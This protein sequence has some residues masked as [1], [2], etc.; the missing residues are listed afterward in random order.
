MR[1]HILLLLLGCMVLAIPPTAVAQPIVPLGS[2][3]EVNSYT[4]NF[5][6]T[7]S[8]A[9]APDG[10]FV[11][12]WESRDQDYSGYGLFSQRYAGGGTALGVEM[13]VNGQ[14]GGDQLAADVA[15]DA[16][17][18]FVVVWSSTQSQGSDT[19]NRSIQMRRFDALG[20]PAGGEQQVNTE[21][22]GVQQSPA[23]ALGDDGRF[24]VV[25]EGRDGDGDGVRGQLFLSDG[26]P[27]GGETAINSY[28]TDDQN[29]VAV[30]RLGEDFVVVWQGARSPDDGDGYGLRGRRVSSTGTL[31]GA[32][33]QI[34]ADPSG[35]QLAP[36]L[37]G[38]DDGFIVS[39][40]RFSGGGV[41]SEIFARRFD[42][43]ALPLAPELQVNSYTTGSQRG[44]D[45]Q[46]HRSGNFVVV[47]GSNGSSGS[48]D[49]GYSVQGRLLSPNGALLGDS[50]QVNTYTTSYQTSPRLGVDAA[51]RFVVAWSSFQNI[52]RRYGGP[53]PFG[54]AV[55]DRGVRG[56]RFDLRTLTVALPALSGSSQGETLTLDLTFDGGVYDVASLAFSIDYDESCLGFDPTDADMDGLPDAARFSL[57]AAFDVSVFFDGGDLDG[58]IDVLI[59]DVP[60]EA[61]LVSGVIGQLDLMVTC[62]APPGGS[63]DAAVDFSVDPPISAGDTAGQ[64][65]PAS[66]GAGVVRVLPG[67]RGDCNGDRAVDAADLGASGLELFDGDG[68]FWLD[69]PAGTFAGQP[70][71]C[72]ANID[73]RVDAG[74]VSCVGRRIFALGCS[75]DAMSERP[76]LRLPEVLEVGAMEE[77]VGT[78]FFTA[79]GTSINSLAFSVDYD[80]NRLE[81][82]PSDDDMDGVPDAIRFIGTMAGIL[83]VSFEGSDGDGELDFLLTDPAVAPQTFADG[84]LIEIRWRALTLDDEVF[85][86]VRF[87]DEPPVSF[88]DTEGRSVPGDARVSPPV[89]FADGFE[90]GAVGGWSAAQP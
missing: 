5:Q 23:V 83:D 17:G 59:A 44:S 57:P 55:D 3:F 41:A 24:L 6:R 70:V 48:D 21:T 12:V 76:Q 87:A 22:S 11:V 29:S 69:V 36:A 1:V 30:G 82:D 32:E 31:M 73:G 88:G 9:V 60:P 79:G 46:L 72:D 2:E 45:V 42:A 62:G 13:Q 53:K 81:F 61:V 34:N 43:A 84:A 51:G 71:G 64:S 63:F 80:A 10:G 65:L 4:T 78:V 75:A 89:L 28:T 35:D 86:A 90:S 74:D 15:M 54:A 27:F 33:F 16:A 18:G 7:P 25:W 56:Q 40:H 66:G 47:W 52:G 50:F 39:W 38:D 67:P 37:S 19:D 26:T 8:L 77:V 85:G 20:M 14:P 49:D 68:D 58:E